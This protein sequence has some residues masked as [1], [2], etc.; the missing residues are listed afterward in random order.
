MMEQSAHIVRDHNGNMYRLLAVTHHAA[1]LVAL[2]I[3]LATGRG[4]LGVH[5]FYEQELCRAPAAPDC[6]RSPPTAPRLVPTIPVS[7]CTQKQ[8][9]QVLVRSCASENQHHHHRPRRLVKQWALPDEQADAAAASSRV[10]VANTRLPT[11]VDDQVRQAATAIQ[12]ASTEGNCR[13]HTLR[14]LLPVIG[15]TE[16]DDWPGGARQMMEA[17]QPLVQQI[18]QRLQL[19]TSR[20]DD[21]KLVLRLVMIDESD[22]VGAILAQ[23]PQAQDDSCTVLLPSADTTPKLRELEAQVGP[24]RNLIVVNPQWK[25]R[26]DFG[27]GWG[28]L[29][30]TGLGDAAYAEQFVPTFSLTNLI[31]EGESIRIVRAHPGPW[32]V[33]VRSVGEDGS[34]DWLPLGTKAFLDTKPVGWENQPANQRDGGKLFDFGQPT[35]QEVAELLLSSP[36]FTPKN[37]AERAAAAFDFIKDSL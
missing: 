1:V 26:S 13:R 5:A 7:A 28:S 16:L 18:L 27:G 37:P 30:Q 33:F 8:K 35:Y 10:D 11:S 32:R 15:A 9:K 12:R 36:N 22:G 23:A 24:K 17:A 3:V 31:C 6:S 25:R 2:S 4:L 21:G 14:L 29:F 34:V 19:A 20:D